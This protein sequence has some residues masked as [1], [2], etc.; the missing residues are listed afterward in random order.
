ML[1]INR[2][3]LD[4][5]SESIR[6]RSGQKIDGYTID[7]LVFEGSQ[8]QS[9]SIKNE[10]DKII[11]VYYIG[12]EPDKELVR[13]LCRQSNP[14][15]LHIYR[16]GIYAEHFYCIEKRYQNIPS[17]SLRKKELTEKEKAAIRAFHS[18]GFAHLDI[19]KEHFMCDE[20]GNVVLI[21][22]GYAHRLKSRFNKTPSCFSAPEIYAGNYSKE[23][24]Y[25][26]FGITVLEQFFPDLF[27]NKT[28]QEI[29][30]F[31]NS[32][33][34]LKAA[35]RLPES[36]REDV[37][38]MLADNPSSRALDK[39]EKPVQTKS[40]VKSTPCSQPKQ[41]NLSL[42]ELKPLLIYE[43][44]ELAH[45]GDVKVFQN[46]VMSVLKGISWN[47]PGSVNAAYTYLKSVP[48]S[49]AEKNYT[50][51][52]GKN[53]NRFFEKLK[54]YTTPNRLHLHNPFKYFRRLRLFKK[55]YV[56]D[57]EFVQQLDKKGSEIAALNEKRAWAILKGIGITLG[58]LCA[59][60]VAIGIIIAILYI[61]AIIIGI[62]IVFCVIAG[63]IAAAGG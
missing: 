31:V 7:K 50:N 30:A 33:K 39:A 37:K 51:L 10:G 8:S 6:F 1:D 45:K 58:V 5:P 11:K 52:C 12:E 2:A 56:M 53:I 42:A 29:R 3:T 62:I 44:L 61:L 63:L 21:D 24:D 13:Q 46:K 19:K 40:I 43:V 26:S 25:Y 36:V 23:S 60:A 38:K 35:E 22:I 47:N 28:K 32:D 54:V 18:L 41:T 20:K 27:R 49:S 16:Y 48:R 57:K 34:P 9:F 59:I 17:D 15:L 55:F 14:S 4:I